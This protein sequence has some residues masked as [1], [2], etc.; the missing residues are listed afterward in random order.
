MVTVR[1]S[2]DYSKYFR[3]SEPRIAKESSLQI[4]LFD[5][6]VKVADHVVKILG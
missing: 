5:L 3:S 6:L 1:V 4:F 2:I